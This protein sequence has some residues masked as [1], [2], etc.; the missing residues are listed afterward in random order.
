MSRLRTRWIAAFAG[1]V[2]AVCALPLSASAL[3][4]SGTHVVITKTTL[5]I[6]AHR[7]FTVYTSSAGNRIYNP[8]HLGVG[9]LIMYAD[10]DYSGTYASHSK[11]PIGTDVTLCEIASK[12]LLRCEGAF[13]LRKSLIVASNFSLPVEKLG[14]TRTIPLS[15]GT[16]VFAHAT[17]AVTSTVVEGN[18]LDLVVEITRRTTVK[19]A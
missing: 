14:T 17:G 3:G 5:H 6:Y 8:S 10:T 13:Q 2:L 1:L 9:S 18:N 12:Q 15:S 4:G 7:S 16:G 19:N 11:S